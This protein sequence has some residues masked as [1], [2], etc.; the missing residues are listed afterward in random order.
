MTVIFA[1]WSARSPNYQAVVELLI[2]N[3]ILYAYTLELLAYYFWSHNYGLC[4]S[5]LIRSIIIIIN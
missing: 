1:L 2:A 4:H 5:N 3:E